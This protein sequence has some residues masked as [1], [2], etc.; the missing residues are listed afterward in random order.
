MVYY[1]VVGA[2]G[3]RYGPADID[4]LVQ[5]TREGRI[6]ESTMLIER[7]TEREVRA[8]AITAIVAELRR[9][10]GGAPISIEREPAGHAEIPTLTYPG[11]ARAGFERA[12]R[13]PAASFSGAPTAPGA[14]PPTFE[15]PLMPYGRPGHRG[16]E[17]HPYLSPRSKIVAGLLGIL[18]GGLGVHRFYLG[19]TGIGLIQLLLACTGISWIWGFVEGIIC[20]MGGMQDA[21]GRELRD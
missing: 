18:L 6:I 17:R 10:S 21:E 15:P 12:A 19:Y 7:G 20:F 1:F 5:W 4:T 3:E 11:E 9:Q 16:L 2:D 14:A 13:S 8:D